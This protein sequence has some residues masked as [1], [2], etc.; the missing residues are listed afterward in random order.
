MR[1]SQS[2]DSLVKRR[3]NQWPQHPPGVRPAQTAATRGFAADPQ[4]TSE[5]ATLFSSCPAA[6]AGEPCRMACG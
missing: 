4:V 5:H 1:Q 2:L 6:R 3:L